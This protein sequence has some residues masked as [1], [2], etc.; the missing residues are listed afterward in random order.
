MNCQAIAFPSDA[1]HSTMTAE[2]REPPEA[3]ASLDDALK[4][5]GDESDALNGFLVSH[6]ADVLLVRPC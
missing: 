4:P 5:F 3:R 2:L 1:L 6:I